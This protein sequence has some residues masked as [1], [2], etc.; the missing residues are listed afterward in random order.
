MAKD[1]SLISIFLI[2]LKLGALTFGGGYAMVPLF[3]DEFVQKRGWIACEDMA[4]M[5][6][7]SQSV[8]GAIAINCGILIGYRLKKLRGA[9]AAVAGIILPSLVV[10]TAVTYLYEAVRD[11]AY[12]TGALRGI[13][14]AVV[15]LLVSAFWRLSKPFRKDIISI[16]FFATAFLLS[17]LLNLNSIYIIL[18]AVVFGILIGMFRIKK[19]EK[20]GA[21]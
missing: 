1:K 13:R 4:N 5:I 12:V 16:A 9:L 2:M 20:D 10:L 6:A 19:P 17:L 18:G 7:L 11:N 15:A 14:A 3:E 21:P 8:P